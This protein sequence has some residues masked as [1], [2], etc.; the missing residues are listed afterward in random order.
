MFSFVY[1]FPKMFRKKYKNVNRE[2]T[3]ITDEEV[4]IILTCRKIYSIR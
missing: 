2:Y 4:E 3:D 1:E